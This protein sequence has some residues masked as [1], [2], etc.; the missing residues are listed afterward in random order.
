[1]ADIFQVDGTVPLLDAPFLRALSED[2]GAGG[3]IEAARIFLED[4][5]PRITRM[6]Q[7]DA[8]V[9]RESHGLAGSALAVGLVRLGEAASALQ[10]AVEG[11]TATDPAAAKHLEVLL[12]QSMAALE[13]WVATQ[14]ALT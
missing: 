2:L 12:L 8:I 13:A 11:T 7:G 1:M 5:P 3:A 4:A 14:T 9:R 6:R 10:R